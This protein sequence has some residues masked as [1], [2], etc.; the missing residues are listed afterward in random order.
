MGHVNLASTCCFAP[1]STSRR[2]ANTKQRCPDR[3]GLCAGASG[4]GRGARRSRRPHRCGLSFS[5]RLSR[6]CHFKPALS[7]QQAA[8]S[9][10]LQLVSSGGDGNNPARR[11]FVPGRLRLSDVGDRHRLSRSRKPAAAASKLIFSAPLARR[12]LRARAGSSRPSDRAD[13]CACDQ[14]SRRGDEKPAGSKTPGGF[15]SSRA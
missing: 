2:A 8:G 4:A 10:L 1:T 5:E 13:N 15:A 9:T 11:R 12:P 3:S 14:R 7:R 6:P